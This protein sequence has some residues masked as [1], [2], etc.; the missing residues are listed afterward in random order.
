MKVT[1]MEW[2]SLALAASCT[3]AGANQGHDYLSSL[4]DSARNARLSE[5][6]SRRPEPCVVQRNFFRGFDAKGQRCGVPGARARRPTPSWSSTMPR[7]R[8]ASWTARC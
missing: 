8:R 2:A 7:D 6:L 1:R 4:S 5:M 3:Q